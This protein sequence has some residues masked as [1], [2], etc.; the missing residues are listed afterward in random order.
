MGF[1]LTEMA[2]EYPALSFFHEGIND[3]VLYMVS[4]YL[5]NEVVE[6]S[7]FNEIIAHMDSVM[8]IRTLNCLNN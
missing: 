7:L 5:E 3:C 8:A 4:D 2:F 6:A 1:Y